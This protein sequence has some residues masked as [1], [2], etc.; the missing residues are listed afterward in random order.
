M[1]WP[2]LC[3]SLTCF[4]TLLRG[5]QSS[6]LSCQDSEYQ[7]E[8]GDCAVCP[9]CPPGEEPNQEC[10]SGLGLGTV[11]RAC[12]PG[13]FSTSLGRSPC[14]PHTGCFHLWRVEVQAGTTTS[15]AQCGGCFPGFY[16][17]RRPITFVCWPC[18]DAPMGTP[19]CEGECGSHMVGIGDKVPKRWG[20]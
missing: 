15:D 2:R 20:E 6:S 10:G 4:L 14:I 13:T 12:R 17:P 18:S 8:A 1:K 16:Y 19:D 9:T 3:W 5:P 11:C 7:T